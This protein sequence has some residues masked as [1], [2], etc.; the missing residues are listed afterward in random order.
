V[1]TGSGERLLMATPKISRL[2]HVAVAVLSASAVAAVASSCGSIGSSAA[3]EYCAILPD[4]VGLYAGNPVTQMGYKIGTVKGI[5]PSGTGVRLDFT[6]T[7]DRPL[8]K[9]VTAIVRST[10]VLADR[11][12]ELVG[13]EDGGPRLAAGECIPISR[14]FTPKSLSEVVG[15]ATN[16][17]NSINPDG[18]TNVADVVHGI[19]Q[20]VNGQGASINRLL[21]AM[22]DVLHSPDRTVNDIGTVVTN[23][24]QL[25]T[26]LSEIR[27]PLKGVLLDV[28]TTLP[29]VRKVTEGGSAVL[30]TTAALFKA[31]A[32]IEEQLGDEVQFTLDSTG[33]TLRKAAAH[34]PALADLLNPV[35]QW[36]N[37]LANHFNNRGLDTI[38]YRPPM[39][40]IHTPDGVALCNIMNASMQGSCANVQGQPY[41]VDVALLQYVL[42]QAAKQ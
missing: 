27:D 29:S 31:V 37:I 21:T 24:S 34:A 22:S 40:R 15:S 1:H 5:N 8:P 19:D 3:T 30:G 4:S 6:V 25:T 18:S 9:N 33:V 14:S 38:R 26:T 23:L 11:A 17:A 12:L 41:A 35:P 13:D 20:A 36:I 32:D 16:L 2:G 39:Y 42:T 28:Q 10:S 7:E